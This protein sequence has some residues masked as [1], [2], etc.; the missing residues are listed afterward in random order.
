MKQ[1][2]FIHMEPHEHFNLINGLERENAALKKKLDKHRPMYDECDRGDVV[3]PQDKR[4][5]GIK[6][7]KKL[8]KYT[9]DQCLK[10]LR[11][12]ANLS[13]PQGGRGDCDGWAAVDDMDDYLCKLSKLAR[14]GGGK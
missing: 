2:D 5:T 13:W 9:L 6:R 4:C 1:S 11:R 7:R 3:Q 14:K 10:Y 8:D 12:A